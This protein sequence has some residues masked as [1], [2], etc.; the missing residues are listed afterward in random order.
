M[1]PHA[2]TL[3][4]PGLARLWLRGQWQGL[5]IAVLFAGLLNGLIVTTFLW[6]RTIGNEQSAVVLNIVG[7]FVVV[8]FW[9]ASFWTTW[10]H[11]PRWRPGA[12]A[13]G[14][15]A[16]FLQAQTEYL[17]GHWYDAEQLLTRMLSDSPRDADAHLLLAALY[18]HTRRY[19]E[20]RQR[21]DLIERLEHGARWLFEIDE[22]RRR[23]A[24]LIAEGTDARESQ[25]DDA[26]SKKAA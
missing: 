7:W 17:Q 2:W 3:V 13:R 19:Q 8:C 21:L 22:E 1:P 6:P 23:L 12:D 11:L 9:G 26:A 10:H 4:W 15:D 5:G 20:A 25:A 16:L 18:R 14:D 24:D